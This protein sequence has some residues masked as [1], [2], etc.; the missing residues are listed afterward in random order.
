MARLDGVGYGERCQRVR[1]QLPHRETKTEASDA[2]LPL[3]DICITALRSRREDQERSRAAT[4]KD[5]EES[6]FVSTTRNGTAFEPR[7]FNC[8]VAMH[9]LRH[10]QIDVTMNVY[11]EV[12]DQKTLK[13]LK[14]LG[15]QLDS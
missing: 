1:Q 9:I 4:G 5:W 3:P 10:A 7:N 14:K 12:S 11:T 8:R 6:G 13:A 15:E 2:T